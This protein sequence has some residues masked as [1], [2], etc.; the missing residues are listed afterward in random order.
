MDSPIAVNGSASS[1]LHLAPA[2]IGVGGS[3][4]LDQIIAVDSDTS[5]STQFQFRMHGG[6]GAD[7]LAFMLHNDPDGTS[8]LSAEA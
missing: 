6:S 3:A 5:F 8:A 1:A 4:F 2:S 7:G